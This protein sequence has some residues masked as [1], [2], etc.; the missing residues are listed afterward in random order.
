M[1]QI[2]L[3]NLCK[4]F[5]NGITAIKDINICIND[6][7]FIVVVGSSGSGKTTLLRIVA[8]ID[9][10]SSGEVYFNENDVTNIN[11]RDRNISMVF[12]SYSLY[13]HMRV[14]KNLAFPLEIK[15]VPK[16]E[17]FNKVKE[18]SQKLGIYSL[19]DRKP[20]E[21]S[22]GQRQRVA[23]GRALIQS[24]DVILLDEPLSNLDTQL[25]YRIQNEILDIHN[26]IKKTFI[27]VTHD[28]IEAMKLGDR[29]V[30]LEKGIVQQYGTGKE[31][32]ELPNNLFVAGF[33]GYPR[34]NLIKSKIAIVNKTVEF[35]ILNQTVRVHDEEM[36]KKV[37][38][39]DKQEVVVG[40]RPDEFECGDH[41]TNMRFFGSVIRSEYA[42]EKYNIYLSTNSDQICLSH[43]KEDIIENGRISFDID[44]K[45]TRLFDVDTGQIIS[46]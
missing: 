18:L 16:A 17:I 46:A 9:K 36:L 2:T 3:H 1:P 22:G 28:Q 12:Q 40:V 33:L 19:L 4:T 34:M 25:R 35:Q 31:L 45:R 41:N 5:A 14:Y 44:L 15:K 8:G 32:F 7:E 43:Y 29:I 13:P 10:P 23:L 42:G 39:Y 37:F 20:S 11:P 24:P 6:G 27:Y 21:L 30:I 26:T 38:K